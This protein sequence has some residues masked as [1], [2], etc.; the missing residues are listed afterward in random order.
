MGRV[1][2]RGKTTNRND[3][4]FGKQFTF[5]IGIH[6]ADKVKELKSIR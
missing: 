4:K 3:P 5:G 2:G 1:Q 6:I